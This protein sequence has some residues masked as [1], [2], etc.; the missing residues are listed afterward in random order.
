MPC[1]SKYNPALLNFHIAYMKIK[2][3]W[4]VSIFVCCLLFY[5]FMI[6]T[7]NST[8][9]RL[10]A[11]TSW[12]DKEYKWK[13]VLQCGTW[14][15]Q[16]GSGMI[17]VLDHMSRQTTYNYRWLKSYVINYV[18]LYCTWFSSALFP[19]LWTSFILKTQFYC[20][21]VK[22]RYK[23]YNIDV[24]HDLVSSN[25]ISEYYRLIR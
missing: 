14:R 24:N 12:Q 1:H 25:F 6:S 7:Q 15:V 20:N 22:E 2:T 3:Y 19:I 9:F 23:L 4:K 16:C 13:D 10:A 5:D 17:L 8:E 21:L 18:W 11:G